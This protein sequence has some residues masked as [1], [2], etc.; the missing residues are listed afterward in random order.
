MKN[1]LEHVVPLSDQALEIYLSMPRVLGRDHVFCS[2]HRG[3][4]APVMGNKVA[5]EFRKAAGFEDWCFQNLRSV[6]ATKMKRPL[7]IPDS[8]INLVQGRLDQSVLAR[9]YDAN[10]YL[11]DKRTAL[12]AW[13]N[14]FDEIVTDTDRDNVVS[15]KE[16]QDG[17]A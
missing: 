4:T 8:I 1:K 5:R 2:G 10:D 3:D 17:Q 12:Q 7:S 16:P 6:V 11:E 15:I 9:N 14:L 13:A